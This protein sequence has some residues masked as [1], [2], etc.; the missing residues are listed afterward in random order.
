MKTIDNFQFAEKVRK[1]R[2]DD[3]FAKVLNG[4]I[5]QLTK[6]EDFDAQPSNHVTLLKKHAKLRGGHLRW[7][8]N[9]D[10]VVVQFVSYE[11]EK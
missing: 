7:Q 5:W 10:C 3:Y 9:D 2:N 6:G 8:I 1:S 11:G 4:A